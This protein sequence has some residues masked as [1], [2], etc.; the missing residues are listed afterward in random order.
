LRVY[1]AVADPYCY[2]GTTVLRNIPGIKEQAAL[3]EFEVAITTQ[4]SDEPLPA[5]RLSIAHYKAI[6][7]HLFQD[8]YTWAGRFRT[9]RISKDGSAFCYP[10]N[11]EREMRRLFA[12]LKRKQYLDRLSREEFAR[13]AANFLSTLNAIHPFREGNG[14]TQTTLLA[15]VAERA[16]HPLSLRRLRPKKFLAAMVASFKGNDRLLEREILLLIAS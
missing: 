15:L 9:V 16:G 6:H 12:A 1:D 7:H 14:R 2:P 13:E 5:G 10:E 4:R 3:D 8:L 11:I